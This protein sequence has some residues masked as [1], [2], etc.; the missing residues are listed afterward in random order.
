MGYPIQY[1][2]G[3]ATRPDTLPNQG[4]IWT[5]QVKDLKMTN[6]VFATKKEAVDFLKSIDNLTEM[7]NGNFTHSGTYYLRHGEY[8][9]AE[10]KPVRY[11]DGW[12]I[13]KLHF[14]YPG[15]FNRPIDGRCIAVSGLRGMYYGDA[16]DL[17]LQD[18]FF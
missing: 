2:H 7:G 12:G 17:V 10:Y 15:T 18:S 5:T 13:K 11:K 3:Q 16:I 6:L 4:T 9:A 14:Y 8:E 1:T